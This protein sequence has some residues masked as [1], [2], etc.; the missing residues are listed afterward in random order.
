MRKTC[1]GPNNTL[2]AIAAIRPLGYIYKQVK[3]VKTYTTT[4]TNTHTVVSKHTKLETP[5]KQ[6]QGATEKS[7]ILVM[8][9]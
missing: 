9:S 1:H 7:T 4:V 5:I 2:D 8:E 6:Q 3:S